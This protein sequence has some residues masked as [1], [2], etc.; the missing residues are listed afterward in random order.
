MRFRS[1]SNYL[2]IN[3]QLSQYHFLIKLSSVQ[4]SLHFCQKNQFSPLVWVDFYTLTQWHELAND[5]LIILLASVAWFPFSFL[6]FR[7]YAFAF[8][9]LIL[10]PK[11]RSILLTSF[12]PLWV[13]F[14]GVTQW[15]KFINY[16]ALLPFS[17][18]K[19][20]YDF[21]MCIIHVFF[22]YIYYSLDDS[23]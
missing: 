21:F 19:S 22:Y 8:F 13:Y 9:P 17:H 14:Y 12:L 6:I 23:S 5:F 3:I 7:I 10:L 15:Q 20:A 16:I 4:M 2:C 18:C 11:N 1:S